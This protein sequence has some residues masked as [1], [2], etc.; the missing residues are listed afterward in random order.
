VKNLGDWQAFEANIV[1][2]ASCRLLR[3]RGETPG[4]DLATQWSASPDMKVFTFKLR[5]DAKF[6]DGT[7]ITSSIVAF[8]LK[9]SLLYGQFAELY[10]NELEEH[11]KLKTPHD[12]FAGVKTPDDHT[13]VIAF[14][15]PVATIMKHLD[16]LS[17]S[18]FHP[19]D[20]DLTSDQIKRDFRACGLY[21]VVKIGPDEVKMTINKFHW[22]AAEPRLF[23][24][25]RVIPSTSISE[26]DRLLSRDIDVIRTL[27]S[28]PAY[29]EMTRRGMSARTTGPS[30]SYLS[31]NFAGP[32]LKQ[33]PRLARDLNI[34]IDREKLVA[35]VNSQVGSSYRTAKGV[36]ANIR[37]LEDHEHS[38]WSDSDRLKAR[39]RLRTEYPEVSNGHFPLV[40]ASIHGNVGEVIIAGVRAQL[41]GVGLASK[42][43]TKELAE[44]LANNRPGSFSGAL[45]GHGIDAQTP[46]GALQFLANSEPTHTN[47]PSTHP[48][49]KFYKKLSAV[50]TYEDHLALVREYNDLNAD[51]GFIIPLFSA[52]GKIVFDSRIDIAQVPEADNNWRVDDLRM[53]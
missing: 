4:P 20:V 24:R 21:K 12:Q 51:T 45:V 28:A 41:A 48:L 8:N 9:R 16:M 14:A 49:F 40:L 11:E 29:G 42:A 26:A 36:T 23:P 5:P 2:H 32:G 44:I 47:L 7:A 27:S 50:R 53:K 6:S 31:M 33:Y 52:E 19:D 10:R 30:M 46:S 15:R 13:V 18:I 22:H 17:F 35:F 43:E 3:Y 37:A 1:F 39:A 34:A 38:R 25:I